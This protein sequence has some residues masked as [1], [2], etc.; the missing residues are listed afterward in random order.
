MMWDNKAVEQMRVVI[1]AS[2]VEVHDGLQCHSSQ[3]CITEDII[4]VMM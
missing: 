3:T 2:V 4:K 1:Q